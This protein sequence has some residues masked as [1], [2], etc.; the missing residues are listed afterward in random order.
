[1]RHFL[2]PHALGF[3]STIPGSAATLQREI[4]GW[5]LSKAP[6]RVVASDLV[7]NV[8]G[9]RPLTAKGIAEVLE[10][11]VI[12][13]WLEPES[14]YPSNRAWTL[15]LVVRA[16]FP[17]RVEAERARRAAIRAEIARIRKP[18]A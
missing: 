7:H 18:A 8:K 4:G 6:Q 17:E 1:V 11:F 13:G 10:P 9:C 14:E 16:A 5:L 2:L 12:G 3:Y 15:D